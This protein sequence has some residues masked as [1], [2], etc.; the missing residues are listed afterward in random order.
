MYVMF[1]MLHIYIAALFSF[2]LYVQI[3]QQ[4]K[5]KNNNNKEN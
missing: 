2:I 1:L 5:N 4:I 3:E